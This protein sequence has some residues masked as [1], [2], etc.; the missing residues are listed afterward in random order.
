MST[1]RDLIEEKIKGQEEKEEEK[2]KCGFSAEGEQARKQKK[3]FISNK[4]LKRIAQLTD[5]H[6]T[7]VDLHKAYNWW[8]LWEV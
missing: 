3:Y 4:S 8:K 6:I 1:L 7:F 5:K 2:E